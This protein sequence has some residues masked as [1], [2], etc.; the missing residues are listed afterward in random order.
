MPGSLWDKIS[1][2]FGWVSVENE[3]DEFENSEMYDDYYGEESELRDEPGQWE[4]QTRDSEQEI[5]SQRDWSKADARVVRLAGQGS[6]EQTMR[7]AIAEPQGFG[8]VQ[9]IADQLKER[10]SVVVNVEGLNKDIAR[11]VIDFLSGTVYALD[12]EMQQVS[13]GVVM[14]VPREMRIDKIRQSTNTNDEIDHREEG[15]QQ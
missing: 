4:K 9:S 2:I 1:G 10:I 3:L 5:N 12:G 8:D 14:F 15:L 6:K 13:A 11:R 7:V